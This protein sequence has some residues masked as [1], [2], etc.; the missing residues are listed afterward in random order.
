MKA[1]PFVFRTRESHNL[2]W[3][4]GVLGY[5]KHTFPTAGKQ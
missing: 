5:T 1:H 3:L 2:L 4:L